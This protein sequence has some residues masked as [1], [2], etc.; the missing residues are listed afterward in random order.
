M[1][2]LRAAMNQRH[3]AELMIRIQPDME[4]WSKHSPEAITLQR[5][6]WSNLRV[7]AAV[8]GQSVALDYYARCSS[9]QLAYSTRRQRCTIPNKYFNDLR[10]WHPALGSSVLGL[11]TL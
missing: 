5:L 3:R 8:L 9:D 1:N 7:V 2:K 4:A 11:A 10:G 6:D